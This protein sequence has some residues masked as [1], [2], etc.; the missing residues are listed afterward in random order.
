MVHVVCA[1]VTFLSVGLKGFQHKNVIG[2]HIRSA[3]WTSYLMG[4]FD[5]LTISM[6]ARH[7]L[8]MA[9]SVGTGAAF[10]MVSAMKL[11]DRLYKR[12]T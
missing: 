6:V 9:L 1:L 7:G 4:L 3:F 5:V 10:G 2:G 8:V 12:A 11:H